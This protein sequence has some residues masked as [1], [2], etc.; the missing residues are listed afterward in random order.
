M[1]RKCVKLLSIILASVMCAGLNSVPVF[2]EELEMMDSAQD[3]L[4]ENVSEELPEEISEDVPEDG[5]SDGYEFTCMDEYYSNGNGTVFFI[6]IPFDYGFN[7][8]RSKHKVKIGET[9]LSL[10]GG[11]DDMSYVNVPSDVT[12]EQVVEVYICS[13]GTNYIRKS[14]NVTFGNTVQP[15]YDNDNEKYT[16]QYLKSRIYFRNDKTVSSIDFIPSG[17]SNCCF[18]N[19]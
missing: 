11:S 13:D 7:S 15:I 8:Y 12:G 3:V 16:E 18:Y 1:R 14:Y 19:N 4:S 10:N 17:K 5:N 6:G 9:E 2:A